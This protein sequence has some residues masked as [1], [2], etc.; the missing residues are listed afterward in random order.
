VTRVWP[1]KRKSGT[2]VAER[3]ADHDVFRGTDEE[4]SAEIARLTA[5]N[6]AA[7]DPQTERRLLWLR[8]L[9][10]IRTLNV[11][12]P[13]PHYPEP[14]RSQLPD[15]ERLPPIAPDH[16]TPE[17]LR[18]GILRDGAVRVRG[19]VDSAKALG[20]ADEIERSL[21]ERERLQQ[22]G[23]AD[24]AYYDEFEADEGYGINI[25][26]WIKEGGGLLAVDA[27]RLTFDMVELFSGAGL[28]DLVNGYLGEPGLI[29]IH[30]TTLR[31]ADPSVGGAW[32]QDGAFM[33]PVR[34]LNLWLSLS[35]CGDEA[36]G[37][38]LVP[39]R[40]DHLVAT[41]TEEAVLDMQ[42]S[43][44]KAEEAAGDAG[45]VRPIFEPGDALL[46]DEL[47]LH[48]TGS[49]PAMPKPRYAIESWFFGASGFPGDYAPIAV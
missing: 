40:L 15:G 49:D 39:R 47:F 19:L 20:F 13:A 45:I 41:Q 3:P 48:A 30:K 23:T 42:V 10:G 2:A 33:G 21:Q 9:A 4:L 37:L 11:E 5:E 46:F 35:H 7:R 24:P 1:L 6:R 29:S 17:L 36:P 8:H 34:A 44:A 38:D 28:Q 22:G 26:W 27:P 25:R 16:L 18:A 14:D 31:K 12:R 32:H 43:Q